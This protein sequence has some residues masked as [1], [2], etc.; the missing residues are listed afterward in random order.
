ME[1][2]KAIEHSA[3]RGQSVLICKTK[4]SWSPRGPL[5]TAVAV[6]KHW[7]VDAPG[8]YQPLEA[9]STLLSSMERSTF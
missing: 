5:F 2:S 6:K 7:N 8:F 4:A 9:M 1:G 3:P